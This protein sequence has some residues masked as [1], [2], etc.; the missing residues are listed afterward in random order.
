MLPA[1]SVVSSSGISMAE[2]SKLG[3]EGQKASK[4]KLKKPPAFPRKNSDMNGR[5]LM[6]G[7]QNLSQFY[8][9]A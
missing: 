9:Q 2:T 1:S 6:N 5:L 4:G 3:K 7:S 8:S